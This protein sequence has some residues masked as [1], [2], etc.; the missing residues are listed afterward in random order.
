QLFRKFYANFVRQPLDHFNLDFGVD[1]RCIFS[2]ADQLR[3]RAAKSERLVCACIVDFSPPCEG[4]WFT[5]LSVRY[6][7]TSIRT[8]RV[9]EQQ[10]TGNSHVDFLACY[11]DDRM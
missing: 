10:P 3:D 11:F 5:A 1:L 6:P 7:A 8:F 2:Q 9:L 4:E